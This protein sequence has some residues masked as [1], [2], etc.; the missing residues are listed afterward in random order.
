MKIRRFILA[1]LWGASLAA[2]SLR[3]NA[4][5]YGFFW[6]VTLI[7]PVSL[8]YLIVVI[9][10]FKLYQELECRDS[11][12]GRPIPYFFVL[13]NEDRF[14]FTSISVK[15]FSSFSYVE[16]MPE[17]TEYELLPG[18]KFTWH[19][20]LICKYRGEYEVGVKEIV[21]KDFFGLFLLRYK[22]PGTIKALVMP[23]YVRLGELKTISDLANHLIQE[24]FRTKTDPAP[25]LRDYAAGDDIRLIHWRSSAKEQKLMVRN[26]TGEEKNGLSIFMDTRRYSE[27]DREYLPL[28][29]KMLETLLAIG[30]YFAEQDTGFSAYCMQRELTEFRVSGI[31][32]FEPF[33][34]FCSN[35]T[36]AEEE[37]IHTAAVQLE[38]RKD[39]RDSSI[40]IF[41]LHRLEEEVLALTQRLISG[42][43]STVIYL[44]TDTEPDTENVA[45]NMRR[46]IVTIPVEAE[47]EGLL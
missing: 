43:A 17:G 14:A 2:I 35:M 8:L 38:S 9:L 26:R 16:E 39:F 4:A 18:D 27:K 41:I 34:Q 46:R 37:T 36:F 21:A 12:S 29:N 45:E 28:E 5:S 32:D 30:G 40:H 24:S 7:G 11:V 42:G 3:G 15:M 19:T 23:R 33:Y 31:R 10:R 1:G 47:L 44:I 25:D 6:A 22:N 20:N 13:Q